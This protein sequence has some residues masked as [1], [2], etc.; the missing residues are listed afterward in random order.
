MTQPKKRKARNY[1]IAYAAGLARR[2]RDPSHRIVVPGPGGA[3]D[4]IIIEGDVDGDLLAREL[5]RFAAYGTWEEKAAHRS[6]RVLAMRS[7]YRG[8][9]ENI[10][11][12]NPSM[13]VT[14]AIDEVVNRF[15]AKSDTVQDAVYRHKPA[16]LKRKPKIRKV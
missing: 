15:N 7:F 4:E 1:D 11:K 16:I 12:A 2:F 3:T 6:N 13:T 14:Q 10:R 9:V 8:H 5:E